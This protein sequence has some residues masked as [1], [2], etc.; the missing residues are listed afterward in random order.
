[1]ASA[2]Q[3]PQA[4][5]LPGL[6]HKTT[7][8]T[9]LLVRELGVLAKEIDAGLLAAASRAARHEWR[10]IRRRWPS[11]DQVR[12]GALPLSDDD[13]GFM[14]GKVRRFRAI[15]EDRA[16]ELARGREAAA[17]PSLAC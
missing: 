9:E 10:N 13:L 17:A 5:R 8:R 2:L 7:P 14:L 6:R 12:M 16:A 1:L 15:L 4:M 3:C 11:E